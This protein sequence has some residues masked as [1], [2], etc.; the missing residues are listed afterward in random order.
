MLELVRPD[1]S[2]QV[3]WLAMAEEFG[4]DR[5]DGGAMG[6]QTVDELRDPA[7]FAAWVAML[8][9]HERDE[10]VPTEMVAST[11]RWVA[12]DG[13]LVGFLSIRHELNDF[14]RELGGHIGYAIRPAERGKGYATA[15]TALALDECRRLGIERVLV[16]CDETNVASATVIERNGGVLEDVRGAKRR[17]W[18]DLR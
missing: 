18:V 6:S 17:Y 4:R 15:A 1:A 5:I 8:L 16:T 7:A 14:L 13:R 3:E 11:T 9:D 2:R 10:N 12:V